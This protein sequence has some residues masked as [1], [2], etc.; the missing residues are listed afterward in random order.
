MRQANARRVP[1]ILLTLT[2]VL[3]SAVQATVGEKPPVYARIKVSANAIV[4][5]SF[6]REGMRMHRCGSFFSFDALICVP[7]HI[8]SHC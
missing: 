1:Y 8:F 4:H 7:Y 6:C 2:A 3:L 5:M